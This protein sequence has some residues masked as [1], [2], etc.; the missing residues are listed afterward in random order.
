[1]LFLWENT[2]NTGVKRLRQSRAVNYRQHQGNV[3]F[4]ELNCTIST[5]DETF[6]YLQ[7]LLC[8]PA[9]VVI[10]T[11]VKRVQHMLGSCKLRCVLRDSQ[12]INK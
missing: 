1:M 9:N 7:I 8:I 2:V 12:E 4:T 6:N 11:T 5:K 10:A 3:Y